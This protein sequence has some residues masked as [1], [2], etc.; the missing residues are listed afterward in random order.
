MRQRLL[1]D[2]AAPQLVCLRL[3]PAGSGAHA[4]FAGPAHREEGDVPGRGATEM[5]L[6][7]ALAIRARPFPMEN[8]EKITAKPCKTVVKPWETIQKWCKTPLE[9]P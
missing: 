7:K 4:D 6:G 3:A 9:G 5:A 1:R 8:H 2:P